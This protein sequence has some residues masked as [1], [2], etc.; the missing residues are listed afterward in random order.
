MVMRRLAFHEALGVLGVGDLHPGGPSVTEVMLG[1][2]SKID[3]RLVLEVG[4]GIGCTTARMLKRGWNVVALEPS[5]VLRRELERRLGVSAYPDPFETFEGHAGPFDAIVGE[6]AFYGMN[7]AGALEKV[8]RL[9][10]HGGLFASLDM[11]W[12]DEADAAEVARIHDETKAVFGIPVASRTAWTW[13]D[14]Q[15]A[16]RDAG[17]DEVFARRLPPD[18]LRADGSTK[19][20]ILTSAARH[21]LAF[22][23]HINHRVKARK[24]R[25]PAGWTETWMAVWRR[26]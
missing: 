13:S 6:S 8:S 1:E 24:P 26:R 21:P 17:F 16:V 2:L 7:V 4:A 23:Q 11:V 18:S 3:P 9:L 20:R 25:V 19:R 5:D 15:G 22:L 14:W 12:T 10:R